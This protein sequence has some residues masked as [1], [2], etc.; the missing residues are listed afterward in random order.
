MS[1]LKPQYLPAMREALSG[2]YDEIRNFHTGQGLD[3][4]PGSPAV[5]E[6]AAFPRPESLVTA[7]SIATQLIESSG[8]HVTAFVKMITAPME[9]IACWTCVRSVLES[10]SLASW[11]LDPSIDARSRVGRE[12][13]IRY[14]GIKQQLK[15]IQAAGGNDSDL[16]STKKRIDDVE[17]DALKLGYPPI[18]NKKGKRFGIGQEMPAATEVIKLMLD[19]EVMYRLLSA[20]AHGHGWTIRSLSFKPVPEDAISPDVGGVP[21]T[22]FEKTVKIDR[23]AWLGL[24]AA[25]AFTKPVWYKCRYFAW[26]AGRLIAVLDRTFDQLQV[27]PAVRFWHNE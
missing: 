10:S 19:E 3:P 8:E 27:K 24:T 26:D 20:V 14:E 11:L 2:F 5:S 4:A 21:V 22:R 13:A 12:F 16:Q 9:P 17:H 23:L 18:V 7:W 6:Q 1:A 15:L 25:M